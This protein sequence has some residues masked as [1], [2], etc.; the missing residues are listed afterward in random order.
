REAGSA[1][2]R[3]DSGLET[4]GRRFRPQ[5]QRRAVRLGSDIKCKPERDGMAKPA[6]EID[7][8]TVWW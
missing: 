5:Q 4:I 8:K 2:T 7:A 1:A 6:T 3:R